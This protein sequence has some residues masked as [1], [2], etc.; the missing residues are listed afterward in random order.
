MGSL[1]TLH[2]PEPDPEA[3]GA[4]YSRQST[5]SYCPSLDKSAMTSQEAT[6]Y[7]ELSHSPETRR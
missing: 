6:A 5:V 7:L 3:D 4:S 1:Q 2:D